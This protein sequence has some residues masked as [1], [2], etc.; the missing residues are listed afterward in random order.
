MAWTLGENKPPPP[1]IAP[2]RSSCQK[3]PLHPVSLL[4]HVHNQRLLG[5]SSNGQMAQQGTIV[6]RGAVVPCDHLWA[7]GD[8]VHPP[9][10]AGSRC[11]RHSKVSPLMR[12]YMRC[13]WFQCHCAHCHESAPTFSRLPW[14]PCPVGPFRIP[15]SGN[16]GCCQV[17]PRIKW[18]RTLLKYIAQWSIAREVR[19]A[20][21][22]A[23]FKRHV[24]QFEC[25]Q[26]DPLALRHDGNL[27]PT[28]I[29]LE[30]SGLGQ[31]HHAHVQSSLTYF[32]SFTYCLAQE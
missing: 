4:S 5:S 11:L 16:V 2:A 23:M 13:R 28:A 24:S 19:H 14:C 31:D 32:S 30:C 1:I 15:L 8:I 17:K 25:Q 18:S 27:Y 21:Q 3:R 20:L 9:P 6:R 12:T 29:Q 7:R 10:A 22:L 26:G